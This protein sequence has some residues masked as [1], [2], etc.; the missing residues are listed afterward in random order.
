LRGSRRG[1]EAV[2]GQQVPD[3][4]ADRDSGQQGEYGHKSSIDTPAR[5]PPGDTRGN[6]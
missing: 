6:Q 2:T 3:H 4:H 5:T 1:G